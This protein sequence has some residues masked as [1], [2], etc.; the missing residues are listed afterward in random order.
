L[1]SFNNLGELTL[2]IALGQQLSEA[3]TQNNDKTLESLF[4]EATVL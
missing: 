1:P 4:N 3:R 2:K